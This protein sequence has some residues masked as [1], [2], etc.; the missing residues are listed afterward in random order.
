MRKYRM[1]GT[2]GPLLGWNFIAALA[3]LT[4]LVLAPEV[5]R[6]DRETLYWIAGLL[7]LAGPV[8]LLAYLVRYFMVRVTVGASG[9]DLSHRQEIP[10]A[11]IQGVELR[12]WRPGPWNPFKSFEMSGCAWVFVF[13]LFKVV[14]FILLVVFL[15]WFIWA[16]LVPVAVLFSPWHPRVVVQLADGTQLVYRDLADAEEFAWNLRHEIGQ[17]DPESEE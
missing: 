4:L 14:L 6:P 7:I 8:A 13:V 15:L 17:A 11:A 16:V 12:G 1:S 10:W 3:I 9:L 2:L 5:R